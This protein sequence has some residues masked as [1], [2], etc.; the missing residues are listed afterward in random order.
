VSV[1]IFIS[2]VLINILL[3]IIYQKN[4]CI[5]HPADTFAGKGINGFCQINYFDMNKIF[6]FN[7]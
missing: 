5:Y 1:F 2:I 7:A 3:L 6:I 4:I